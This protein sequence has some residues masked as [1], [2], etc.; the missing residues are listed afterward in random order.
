MYRSGL[1]ICVIVLILWTALVCAE[2]NTT[3]LEQPVISTFSIVAFDETT[4]EW[5]VAVQSKFLAVGSAVPFAEAGKGAVASQAWGNMQ[6]GPQGLSLLGMDGDAADVVSFL[7]SKDENAVFRQLGVVDSKGKSAAFTGSKC[8]AWAGHLS[9]ENYCVQGNILTGPEVV[10]AMGAAFENQSGSLAERMLAALAAGQDA[11]GDSRGR[12]SAAIL[13]VRE[14]GGYSGLSDRAIDLRVDDHPTP[15]LELMRIYELHKKTFGVMSYMNSFEYFQETGLSEVASTCLARSLDVAEGTDDLE[16]PFLNAVAWSLAELK[17]HLP[18]ARKLAERATVKAPD[19]PNILDT[20]AT[21]CFLMDD[22]TRA[23]ELEEKAVKLSGN[24][25]LFV[26]KLTKWKE[27][28][29]D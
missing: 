16:A 29:D 14:K 2:S 27:A 22:Q 26:E 24:D 10:K 13:V 20:L 8:Q 1:W 28:K 23:I 3:D 19:D 15:I 25:P 4:L 7:T 21:I 18:R 12:Q 6:Y 17:L 9:G 11:G 5:G